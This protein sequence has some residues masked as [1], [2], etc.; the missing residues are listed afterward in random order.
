MTNEHLDKP[1]LFQRFS[2]LFS[3]KKDKHDLRNKIATLVN[4]ADEHDNEP[5][6]NDKSELDLQE[7]ALIANILHLRTMTADDVMVPRADIK[8]MPIPK[9][10]DE[11]LDH[12]RKVNHSRLP[13]YKNQLDDIVGM[14]HVKDLLAC[15][16][17]KKEFHVSSLLWQPLFTAPQIPVLD[18]LLQMRQRH[19]HLALVIDEYGGIDGLVTI[20]DLV[21]TIVGDISDEHDAP[22]TV[23]IQER[24]D[25]SWDIDTRCPIRE[26]EEKI[27]PI[28]TLSEKE[29]E[30]ETVGGLVFHIAGHVPS[31]GEVLAHDNDF[32]FRILDA[33]ARHIRRVRV[34]K[35]PKQNKE[36]STSSHETSK[37]KVSK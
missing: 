24:P 2:S 21:E 33:D 9:T 3:R 10:L 23:M 17:S 19:T 5:T 15:V 30:I 8:A 22:P 25:K 12:M 31:K 29:S 20:E 27:G 13:V 28:L 6:R 34:R 36:A 32:L 26:F 4:Q 1:V 16:G 18:L 14:L 35:I 7:R 11:A 37:A